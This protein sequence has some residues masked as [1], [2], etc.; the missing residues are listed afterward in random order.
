ML[1]VFIIKRVFYFKTL[2]TYYLH[3]FKK[4]M[5]VCLRVCVSACMRMVQVKG[6][7]SSSVKKYSGFAFSL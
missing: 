3:G 5:C 6:R 1:E 7:S 4:V 2:F